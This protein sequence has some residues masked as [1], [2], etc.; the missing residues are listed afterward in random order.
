MQVESEALLLGCEEGLF[1]KID[2]AKLGG[3]DRSL[4]QAV[5]E[6]G[7]GAIVL[8]DK[9]W[10]ENR[11]PLLPGRCSSPYGPKRTARLE[12]SEGV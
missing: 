10:L 2:W 1:E 11:L 4:T 3:R 12:P 7:V 5:N 6:C 9:F 8:D